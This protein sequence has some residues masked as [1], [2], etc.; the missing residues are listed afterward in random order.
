MRRFEIALLA[1]FLLAGG[2]GAEAT[3]LPYDPDSTS[4]IGGNYD[5]PDGLALRVVGTPDGDECID[6]DGAC[7]KPQEECGDDGA[8]DVLIGDDGQV[9]DVICYPTDGVA[10]ESFEGPVEKV[11]NNVVLVF[12]DE[13]DGA[14]VVGDVTIDGNNVTLYGHGPDTS[15]IEGDLHIDK[16][17]SVVR[18][19]RIQGDVTIDKNNPSIVDCVIEGDLT[20]R[21]NNVS[22]ALCEVWGQLLI[23]GNN[24]VL[25]ENRFATPPDVR[26]NNTLCS[27]NVAFTDAD[28]DARVSD[29]ELG[30]PIDCAK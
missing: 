29:S 25:V 27:G 9:L 12:D 24:A 28:E 15:V 1:G 30:D 17:N 8:A 16:N 20:I 19:I 3:R 10:V 13:D 23:E 11:G 6:L 18:G 5:N 2:C 14:D 21:G 7:A 4:L 26:G 22:I